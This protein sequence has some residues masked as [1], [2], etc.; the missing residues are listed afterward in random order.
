MRVV[1]KKSLIALSYIFLSL[2]FVGLMLFSL[3]N[4]GFLNNFAS[5][6]LD[7][8]KLHFSSS[9]I[10]VY[11][12]KNNLVKTGLDEQKN[13]DI[14]DIPQVVIDAFV[15]IEDKDFYVHKGV[16]Y[17]RMIK[18]MLKNISQFKIAEGASTITQ[19]LVKNT[20]LTSEKTF[21]RK[22]NELLLAKKLEEKLSKDEIMGAYLN[23][24][25]FGNGA[26]GINQAS[27]RYFSKDA[28][29]LNLNESAMLAGLIKSPKKFSP[30]LNEENC[31]K[32]RNL[33]L[34]EMC[35]D[36]KISTEE[37]NSAKS[38]ELGLDLNTNFLGNNNFYNECVDEACNILNINEK[39]FLL[40][41]YKIFTYL[42]AD[43]QQKVKDELENLEQYS[44]SSTSD[45]AVL[46]IDNKTGG[47]KAFYGKSDYN[48]LSVSRQPGSIFK[49][50]I[51]YAPAIEN[52]IISPL[53]PILDE[54][55]DIDGYSPRNFKGTYH[56]WTSAKNALANSYNVP[57]VKVL[58]NVGIQ[59][60]KKFAKK[61]NVKFAEND[62]GFSLALGGMTKGVD[63]KTLANCYQAFGNGGNFVEAKFVKSIETNDGKTIFQN[64]ETAT[65]V[66]KES[67]AFLVTDMLK[68]SVNSGTCKRL[69]NVI[70]G[71]IA[72][73]TGTVTGSNENENSDVWNISYTPANT[74]CV[75]FGVTKSGANGLSVTGA[76]GPT[77]MARNIYENCNF[78][79]RKFNVPE[80]VKSV[81]INEVEYLDNNKILLAQ[82]DSPERYKKTE[83]F[84]TDNMPTERSTMFDDID[85]F[86]IEV[87][88]QAD[89]N[90]ANITFNAKKH[91]VYEVF[92]Q[93]E[94]SVIKIE[95]IKNKQEKVTIV[96]EKLSRGNFYT[97][98]VRAKFL[99]EENKKTK[100]SNEVKIFLAQK[101]PLN[102]PKKW[103]Y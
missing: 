82:E 41:K 35:R 45:G 28:T 5:V 62:N 13:L 86:E 1:V 64:A 99:N 80:S 43:I 81:Q 59:N 67:T 38:D 94:D 36:G 6:S 11:D 33:V 46:L 78:K 74:L 101:S 19:Q 39:D 29:K 68:E 79:S 90:K 77:A 52:N 10:D 63:I 66:M 37:C 49:P 73:K 69:K 48:L 47:I 44:K 65:R 60:A 40:K 76:N 53:T 32:R 75:W 88:T 4:F 85:D 55:V 84:A 71:D 12:S 51:A 9:A 87:I 30:I 72:S 89:E 20:H 18:A 24:I 42:E 50:I 83:Y 58:E 61:M 7:N 102:I 70:N 100:K 14:K 22:I 8:D 21:K 56:G 96:D 3:F 2:G 91:L 26:F 57:A 25:Y 98:F 97:Y 23:A 17:K 34:N 15:S 54:K 103:A 31:I 95:E 16:N 93:S 92:R 27:Q